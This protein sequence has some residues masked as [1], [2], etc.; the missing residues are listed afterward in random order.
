MSAINVRQRKTETLN[1]R[2]SPE[3][4]ELIEAAAQKSG[5]SLSDYI[6]HTLVTVAR[7]AVSSGLLATPVISDREIEHFPAVPPQ[8]VIAPP[9]SHTPDDWKMW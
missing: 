6:V 3:H 1:C 5:F 8:G 4:K 2:I 9:L 7:D